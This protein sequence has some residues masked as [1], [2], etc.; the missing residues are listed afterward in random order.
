MAKGRS[1]SYKGVAWDNIRNKWYARVTFAGVRYALGRYNT[2]EEANEVYEAAWAVGG[3][4]VKA[5]YNL[6]AEYRGNLLDFVRGVSVHQTEENQIKSYNVL[7][8]SAIEEEKD[9]KW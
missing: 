4:K 9:Y 7:K 2:Y 8:D 3:A 1:Y 6:P 5:W